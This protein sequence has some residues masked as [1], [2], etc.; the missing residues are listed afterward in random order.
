MTAE[1]AVAKPSAK[2][3]KDYSQEYNSAFKVG[4]LIQGLLAVL[5]L[6]VLD[7]G[8]THRAF[9]VSFLCQW[10]MVWIILL[11]RPTHPTRLDLAI[12]RYGIGPS[13]I[14]IVCAGPWVLRMLDLN[15]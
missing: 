5:T 3:W 15:A 1:T 14:L 8:Q 12:V 6:L 7:Y 11:R 9:W 2:N 13:L 10:A 4:L